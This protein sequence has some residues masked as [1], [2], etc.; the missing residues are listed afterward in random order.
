MDGLKTEAGPVKT[1]ELVDA[2][3]DSRMWNGFRFRDDDIIVASPAKA[4][5]T[6]TLAILVQLLHDA[7]EVAR[8]GNICRWIDFALFKEGRM[9]AVEAQSHRRVMKCHLPA[10]ALVFSPQAKYIYVARDGRDVAWSE[11]NHLYNSSDEFYAAANAVR[12]EGTPAIDRPSG[13]V[14]AYYRD[15]IAG[16][17]GMGAFWGHVRSW[18]A[19]RDLPNLYLLHYQNLK[20][21]LPGRVADIA[22]YLGIEV[23]PE[24]MAR[25]V[26]HASFGHMKARSNEMFP[27]LPLVGGGDTFI[28]KG[29]NGRWRDVLSAVEIA[30]YEAQAR[31]KLGPDCAAW[32]ATG[33]L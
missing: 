7:P 17:R 30:E 24:T 15:W 29:T 4:G 19:L 33:K 12:P 18:W 2:F 1:R 6:W 28:N 31:D 8:V 14:H 32:L 23:D 27:G 20:D 5:T 22:D 13:D 11:H 3:V 9:E 16:R 10:D 21:D 25:A 26:E